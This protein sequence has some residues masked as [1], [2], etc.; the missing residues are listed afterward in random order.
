MAPSKPR[1]HINLNDDRTK[2]FVSRETSAAER[3]KQSKLQKA[4]K[5]LRGKQGKQEA[6]K[7]KMQ[8]PKAGSIPI[9]V[10]LFSIPFECL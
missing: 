10:S 5:V 8:S 4:A 2:Y 1:P 3:R 7:E 9:Y 6:E